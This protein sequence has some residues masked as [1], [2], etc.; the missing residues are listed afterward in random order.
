V[1]AEGLEGPVQLG[2]LRKLGCPLG[3]GLHIA[4]PLPLA[5]AQLLLQSSG[6]SQEPTHQQAA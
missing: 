1:I 5:D 6:Q 2:A 3:Q 4:R